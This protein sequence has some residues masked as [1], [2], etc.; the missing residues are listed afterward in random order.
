MSAGGASDRQVKIS[1]LVCR[2]VVLL[3]GGE[4]THRTADLVPA[5][6]VREDPDIPRLAYARLSRI[7]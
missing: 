5:L 7:L 1:D 4:P 2:R 3:V 6:N